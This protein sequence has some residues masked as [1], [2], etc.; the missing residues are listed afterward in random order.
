MLFKSEKAFA[1]NKI[2][3]WQKMFRLKNFKKKTV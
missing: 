3:F 1:E 2:Y